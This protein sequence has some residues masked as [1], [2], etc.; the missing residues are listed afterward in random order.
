MDGRPSPQPDGT[1]RV[2]READGIHVLRHL[3]RSGWIDLYAFGLTPALPIDFQVAHHF[4]STFPDSP[5]VRTL[6]VQRSEP[7]LRRILRGC[8]YTTRVGGVEST[9]ETTP[10]AIPDVLREEFGLDVTDEEVR[11]ALGP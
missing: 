5:F 7:G 4:T 6:T 9:R 1:Y 2:D 11:A 8:T 3:R 10:M